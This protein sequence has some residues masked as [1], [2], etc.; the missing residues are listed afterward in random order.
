VGVPPRTIDVAERR[1]RL[2]LRH[3]LA[4]DAGVTNV[5]EAARSLVCLHGTDP[6]SVYLSAWARVE[7]MAVAD[8]DRALY[9]DRS[10][11]KHL[12]MRRTLFVLPREAIDYAQAGASDSVAVRERR[13]LI[14][15]VEDA[16]LQRDGERWLSRACEEVMADRKSVV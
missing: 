5:T 9:E 12:A 11:I 14:R 8:L 7:P 3:C 4:L 6:A 1:A 16:G 2:A 15:L 10:L 13:N